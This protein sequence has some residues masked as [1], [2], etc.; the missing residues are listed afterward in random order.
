MRAKAAF[1]WA[2]ETAARIR[3]EERETAATASIV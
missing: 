2:S 1:L 3:A